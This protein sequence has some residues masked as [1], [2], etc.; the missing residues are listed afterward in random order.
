MIGLVY[1]AEKA[2]AVRAALRG[3]ASSRA[4]STHGAMARALLEP[5]NAAASVRRGASLT[6]ARS[7]ARS[8]ENR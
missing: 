7:A 2:E 1:G 5:L 8:R 3:P 4:S 6:A